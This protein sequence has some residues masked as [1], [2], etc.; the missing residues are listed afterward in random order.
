MLN[1]NYPL[2]LSTSLLTILIA[3]MACSGS[4]D[5]N[6]PL[7]DIDVLAGVQTNML[8]TSSV[9]GDGGDIPG[10]HTCYGIGVSPPVSWTNLPPGTESLALIVEELDAEAPV[11]W[12]VYNL[13]PDVRTLPRSVS[14]T[15]EE[16]LGGKQGR[17]DLN[18]L[19]WEGPCPKRG[20]THALSYVFNVYALDT[21]LGIGIEGGP[22]RNDVLRAMNGHVIGHGRLTG[23]YCQS[24]SSRGD[25]SGGSATKGSRGTCPPVDSKTSDSSP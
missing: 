1:L 23:N 7:G 15:K 10:A 19:G 2:V 9:F 14:I 13:P 6:E 8:L 22:Q 21:V 18:R 4:D 20:V 16:V 5:K 25:T 12:V 17:N 3:V 11:R 24:D